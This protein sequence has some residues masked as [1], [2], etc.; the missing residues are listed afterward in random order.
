MQPTFVGREREL[1]V[2]A[3]LCQRA[4]GGRRQLVVV[5]GEA[6]I[7]KTWLCERAAV[8]AE[9]EGFEVV[10][11]R[12]WPHGGAP[13]LWPWPAV[14]TELIGPDGG[15]LLAQDSG[16]DRIDPERFVRFA[17]VAEQLA[18]TGSDRPRMIIIDDAHNADE[19]ALLLTRFLAATLD[20]LPLMLVLARRTDPTAG[21]PTAEA[22][23]GELARDATTLPLYR[24]NLHD[25]ATLLTAH[26]LDGSDHDVVSALLK[27]TSGSPLYLAQALG[28][29][30]SGSG[31]SGWGPAT[32]QQAIADAIGRLPAGI[33]RIVAFAAL[34][35]VD[36]DVGEIAALAQVPPAQVVAALRATEEAGLID[37]APGGFA[38]H[39]VVR[40]AA[41]HSLD[42]GQLLD[43]HARAA[44]L[45][46]GTGRPERVAYHALAAAPRSTADADVAITACRRA[47]SALCRGFAYEPAAVLLE[48]AAILVER[49]P[50]SAGR[51]EVLLERAEAVLACG[52]LTQA[53]A[54]FDLATEA[55]QRVADPVLL[56]RAVLGLGGVW[57]HEHRNP[58]VRGHVLA[59]QRAA[60]AGLP[61]QEQVLRIRLTVRLAAEAVYEGEPVQAVLDALAQSRAL[62][63]DRALAESLSLAHHALLAPEHAAVRRPLADEQIAVA[64]SAGDGVLALFGLLW[65][66]VDRYLMGSPEADRCLAELR[67]RAD[68]LSVATIG[69]IVACM[70]VMRLIRA[71][72]LDEAEAAADPCLQRGL[73]VGDA[74]ATGYHASQLLTIRWLQGRDAELAELVAETASSPTLAKYEYGFRA[75][76][77]GVLARGGRLAQ[78]RA[79][80]DPLVD[81]GLDTLPRSSTWLAAMVA[82]VEAARLLDDPIVAGQAAELL[83]PFAELPTMVSL[84]TSCLGATS[85][86]LGLA[87][88]TVGDTT[89]AVR[90]LEHAVTANQ[91]LTHLPAAAL[92]QAQLAEALL[93]R[94]AP[95]DVARAR[96]L[97]AE[98]AA[99]ARA[100][101]LTAR[102][103]D[104][105]VQAAGLVS[106]NAPAL[107]R[108]RG[109]EGWTVEVDESRIEL[110][111]LVGL[112]Y[113]SE[114]LIRPG[115]EVSAADLCGA[116]TAERWQDVL[117]PQAVDAYRRRVRD[118]D[119]AI[120]A[121]DADADLAAAERLRLERE[122]I[123][124]E[125]TRSLGLGGRIRGFAATP[126]RARTAVRKAIKRAL[127]VISAADPILG[128]EL[129]AA[130]RTGTGCRYTP[131]PGSPRQWKID[132]G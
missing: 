61:E 93:A 29:G 39:D 126:E 11:G 77:S 119:A 17:A 28:P 78:A 103:E 108:H 30:R 4:V 100:I 94:D 48:R 104:W 130:V 16:R 43:A 51:T 70:D 13:A 41:L 34:L 7:G 118:L 42:T 24:F 53:R 68:A 123:H 75:S 99:G 114:L 89:G 32:V 131:A 82:I 36:A 27:L 122:A 117:D 129:R 101:G 46:A 124:A 73:E 95:G 40:E 1:G 37:P 58:A 23:H 88:L 25:T 35:G 15:R 110:P 127:D 102:A 112:G 45:L 19:S 57:V 14:L 10:W 59:R 86:A 12:C 49:R 38:F 105:A 44:A 56:A 18:S 54:A 92:S 97:L 132:R 85:R 60:L 63:D 26:G 21:G 33:Q 50:D 109:L 87:A 52:R 79:A 76:V 83:A 128:D 80:L 125:L 81:L 20:R 74:D 84:A 6:G 66:T 71:G 64:S 121:A 69:Y 98:A 91:R 62:G 90:Y 47:A 113:L 65:R 96:A 72:R 31:L 55:A 9:G 5:S 107:L 67:Q 106:S 22:L 111:D 120:D 2:L 116:G 115:E 8:I 3:E